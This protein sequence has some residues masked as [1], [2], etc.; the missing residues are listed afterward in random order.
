MEHAF[1]YRLSSILWKA[2]VS[3]IVALAIYV[4]FGRFLMSNV[5]TYGDEILRELNARSIF[6]IEAEEVTGEW[7]SFTPELVLTGLQLTVPGGTELPLKLA[8]GRIAIDV[9]DSLQTRSLQTYRVSLD[10]PPPRWIM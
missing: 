8:E 3:I 4:S 1:F 9:W 6:M 10:R 2:I 5:G 7:H